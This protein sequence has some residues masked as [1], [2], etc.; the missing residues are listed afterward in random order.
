MSNCE[1][2]LYRCV[3]GLREVR[4]GGGASLL[5]I[6]ISIYRHQYTPIFSTKQH[7]PISSTKTR[8]KRPLGFERMAKSAACFG[9]SYRYL[10]FRISLEGERKWISSLSLNVARQDRCDPRKFHSPKAPKCHFV[11]VL[12]T[13]PPP[14]PNPPLKP[15]HGRHGRKVRSRPQALLYR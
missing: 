7:T 8:P 15:R 11:A 6:T 12:I 5:V 10:T 4:W 1:N 3:S 14:D 2:L 13:T 9:E